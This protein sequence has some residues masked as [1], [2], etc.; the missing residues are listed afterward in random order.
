MLT[1]LYVK[2]LALV[3]EAQ[4][5]FTPGLNILTGET[6][7]GKSVVLGAVNLALGSKAGPDVIGRYGE[8]AFVELE[9]SVGEDKARMLE[10]HD[11]FP[12][13]GIIT[14][15]R[16]IMPGRSIIKIN[17]ESS[18]MHT[19]KCIT[20]YLLDIHGQHEHQSLLYKAK[21]LEILDRF[22]KNELEP[23]KSELDGVYREYRESEKELAEYTISSEER[24]R[25][26]S[27]LKFEADE[28]SGSGIHI[29]ED[30][31]VE[32]LYR[33][34]LNS[35]KI[36]EQLE[37]VE[38]H[39]SRGNNNV[40]DM[41]SRSIQSISMITEYDDALKPLYDE[42]AD[43]ENLLND[44]NRDMSSYVSS[45]EFDEKKF[46]ETEKRLNLINGLKA[47]YGGTIEKI[48]EYHDK[49]VEKLEFYG[50]YEENRIAAEKRR[51]D[52]QCIIYELCGKITDIRKRE[53]EKLSERITA[54][55]TDLNFTQVHFETEVRNTG[56]PGPTGMDEAE[57]MISLNTG[58]NIKP[59]AGIASGGELSRIMLGIKSVLADRDETD[60]LIFDEIDAGISGRTAQR[61]SEKMAYIAGNHQIICITHLPQIAAMADTHFLIEKNVIDGHSKTVIHPI[62]GDGITE[63][64]SRMLSGSEI[65]D[66]VRSN[67]IQMKEMA[68]ELKKL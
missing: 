35:R 59:L 19:V 28:I 6:G 23:L 11:I 31:E 16:R 56:T 20:E 43:I 68:N 33:R 22:A 50:R 21:H 67:A 63:E 32:G 8:S 17:G 37:T 54:A 1:N 14:I 30:E 48:L 38:N 47:K 9:F 26:I 24:E 44:F 52:L 45:F 36:M 46:S 41:V 42:L 12:E 15:S 65:T 40:S 51:D 18:N 39:I 62:E 61:V 55:L 5:A 60:T 64:L 2:N 29:G 34:I 27:F 66:I 4:I 25:N 3:D 7:A 13:N 49:A 58:E 57:F 53:A 10:E